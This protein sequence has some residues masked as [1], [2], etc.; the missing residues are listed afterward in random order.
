MIRGLVIVMWIWA[1][2]AWAVE[3]RLQVAD[4]QYLTL[5]SYDGGNGNVSQLQT[6]LDNMEFPP[7]ALIPGREVKLL[8]D[9]LYGGQTPG[10]L[11]ILPVTKD[12]AWTTLIWDGN[13]GETLVFVVKSEMAA[14]QEVRFVAA[15]PE[16]TLRQIK[17]GNPSLFGGFSYEVPKVSYNFLANAVDQRTF[18]PWIQQNAKSL[19]GLSLV[20]GEGYS[21]YYNPDRVYIVLSTP[22]A[23]RTFKV[24]IGWKDNSDRSNEN[25]KDRPSTSR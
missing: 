10:R 14:W 9:P 11:S 3:Y 2:P 23:P 7:S 19:N 21:K 1:L 15:N 18:V 24:V 8:D 5:S 22:P 12:Q 17:I 6:R 20:I 4:L 16:G 13:P 25:S